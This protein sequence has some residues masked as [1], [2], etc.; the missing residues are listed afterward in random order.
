MSGY[1]QVNGVLLK[2]P[3]T[4]QVAVQDIDGESGR[5]A[6]GDMVR[7]RITQKQKLDITW[8]ALTDLEISTIL[9]AVDAPFFTATYPNPKTGAMS[10]KTFYV[11]DRTA[12]TYSW[13][14]KFPKWEGLSMNF[15]EK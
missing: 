8:G 5:N 13:N 4:F 6:N 2:T 14:N 7:D 9:Q 15:I 11:G 3:Q 1:L 10:T 12:P